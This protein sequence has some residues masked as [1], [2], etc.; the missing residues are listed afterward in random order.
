MEAANPQNKELRIK[1]YPET[2]ERD[3]NYGIFN[4]LTTSSFESFENYNIDES[5]R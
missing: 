2:R 1:K 4:I 3:L 5:P